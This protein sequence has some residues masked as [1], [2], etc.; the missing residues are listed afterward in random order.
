M[1]SPNTMYVTKENISFLVEDSEELYQSG[2]YKFWLNE[3]SSWEKH[4]FSVLNK[5][6]EKEKD[7]LDIGA[8]VGPT[9]LY[10]SHLARRVLAIEPDPIAYNI[11][12]RNIRLNS[13]SNINAINKAATKHKSVYIEQCS[14]YGDSMSR[15]SLLPDKG[16]KVDG[17]GLD[18]LLNQGE[19][20]L[21]KMDIEG[22]EFEL[23][24]DYADVIQH[25]AIPVLVSLH[26]SFVDNH[27]EKFEILLKSI[28]S[29]S[30]IF[31]EYGEQ[32]KI[33]QIVPGFGSY[34]FVW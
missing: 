23:I 32:I 29:A 24:P 19:F 13:F 2:D 10:A 31:D 21:A 17:I 30:K 12:L 27:D 7:Y 15:T 1:K 9:V 11:L 22:Y 34:L 16:L 8:W 6:L 28:S 3:Y 20:S 5:F 14:F 26:S 18:V 4:T 33:N 25:Y